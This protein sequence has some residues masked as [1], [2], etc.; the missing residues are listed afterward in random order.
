MRQIQKIK[1]REQV[2]VRKPNVYKSVIIR[3]PK[4]AKS[5]DKI[6]EQKSFPW[7]VVFRIILTLSIVFFVAWLFNSSIFKVRQVI[8]AGNVNVPTSLILAN[9]PVNDNLWLYPVSATERKIRSASPLIADVAIYRGVPDVIKIQ[10]AEHSMIAD[11]QTG[12][13]DY[14]LGIDGQLLL[15][16]KPRK[17]ILKLDDT[18][19]LPVHAG[20]KVVTAGFVQFILSVEHNFQNII[21]QPID[22][23]EIGD[24]TFAITVVPKSGPK[25][26]LDSTRDAVV[27]LKAGKL[28]LNQYG[29]NI[30]QYLDLRV[31][32]RAYYQ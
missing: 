29:K 12:G 1:S 19:N 32:G 13:Q 4:I 6:V 31:P 2:P 14:I 30:K 10:I 20:E 18:K 8:V 3:Q 27:Q 21:G 7:Q 26:L 23:I 25:I 24:T 15:K 22:H 16:E 9:A 28:V 5:T 11:W 17:P